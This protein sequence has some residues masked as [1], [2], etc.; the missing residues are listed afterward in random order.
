MKTS[1]ATASLNRSI[2]ARAAKFYAAFASVWILVS[3]G[4]AHLFGT[5]TLAATALNIAK[6]ELFV[7]VTGGALYLFMTRWGQERWLEKQMLNQRLSQLSTCANDIILLIGDDGSI[8]DA[9][10][11]AVEAY[12]RPLDELLRMGIGDLRAE[13]NTLDWRGQWETVVR[14]GNVRFEALHLRRDGTLF[15]VEVSARKIAR[16]DAWAVQSIIRDI[17]ERK[18]AERQILRLRDVYA[19][20]SQTNQCIVRVGDRTELFRTICDIAIRYGHFR[21]A[22]IGLIDTETRTV[23][24]VE[25][26]GEDTAALADVH[27]PIDPGMPLAGGTSSRAVITLASS[28]CND[29]EASE[30]IRGS[31]PW[32]IRNGCRSVA[33]FPLFCR[34]TIVGVLSL[35]ATEPGFFRDDLVHLLEEMAGDISYALDRMDLEAERHRT[36]FEMQKLLTAVEQSPVTMVVTDTEGTIEYVNPAFTATSGYSRE[37]AI[38][39]NPSILRGD[40]DPGYAELWTR[41]KSGHAWR[42]TFHNRRKDGTLFWE[43]AVIAPVRDE[44]GKIR[45]FVGIK[46]DVTR[47]VEAEARLEFLAHHDPLTHLP[48]RLLGK[49]RAEQALRAAAHAGGKA[50]LL[51]I[52]VDHFRRINDSLGHATGD[53]LLGAVAE[54]LG[55]CLEET[56]TLCRQGNDEFLIVLPNIRDAESVSRVATDIFAR[57][58]PPLAAAGHTLPVGLSA[59]VALFPDDGEDFHALFRNADAALLQAKESGGNVYCFHDQKANLDAREYTRIFTGL[60]QAVERREFRLEYQPQICLETGRV[61]GAEALIRWRHPERGVLPPAQFIPT[62]EESGLIIEIGDWVLE[63]ACN[64]AEAWRGTPAE[65]VVVAVNISPLQFR[66][67]KLAASIR[68]ALAASGLEAARLELEMTESGIIRDTEHVLSTME[69]IKTIGTRLSIDDFGTGYSSLAY[70]KR[71]NVSK[72]KIDRTF[73]KDIRHNANNDAI[74][75][76][77]VQLAR[78]LGIKT[79]AEGVEDRE[80]LEI[81]RAHGCDEVQGFFFAKPLPLDAF[82]DYVASRH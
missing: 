59:G 50:A 64:C 21:M 42:G 41:I 18:E 14:E 54:R 27:V 72:L 6:G 77:I 33:A 43:E 46:Q 20:L 5:T 36:N 57:M 44:S 55:A 70:L 69:Q 51:L 76:A 65:A 63:E 58:N 22:W 53:A 28:I 17:S 52:D 67:G 8:L 19:A 47:R 1:D 12:G 30:E 79:I 74:V 16:G 82:L 15:P 68:R 71:F 26:A 49:D 66:R 24:P 62:A 45:Q 38:G 31:H 25:A 9:N 13:T 32:T 34:G 60:R 81:V 61:V 75:R 78:G 48:N 39:K 23:V 7:A 11:R 56:D 10:D 4:A 80:T 3:D 35:Y 73:I 40:N 37:E 29:V 2:A